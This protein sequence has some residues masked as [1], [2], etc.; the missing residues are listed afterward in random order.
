[1]IKA[2]RNTENLGVCGNV[3]K[4]TKMA[5]GDLV[6]LVAGD[7]LLPAGILAKYTRF[8]EEN[9]LDC[10]EPF[11]IYTNAELLMPDGSR[12][13]KD[14]YNLLEGEDPLELTFLCDMYVWDT[15]LSGGLV[16][17]TP[18]LREDIGFQADWLQ[19]VQRILACKRYSRM[20]E[21]GYIYRVG[22]G[23]TVR[24]KVERQAKSFLAV[25]DIF[26]TEYRQCFTS[27]VSRF[28]NFMESYSS[29]Q[30]SQSAAKYWR[31]VI[32]RF[33]LRGL[34]KQNRHKYNYRVFI[35]ESLKVVI[36]KMLKR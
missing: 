16:K 23:V 3:N 5:T 21:T 33:K 26:K 6:N 9:N 25:I 4:V 35:P 8:I 30:I 32:D 31:Y 20:N 18:L 11:V 1:M 7:D 24:E 34:S 15:G 28:L 19:H 2:Y 13:F 36:R 22:G 12:V 29:Y 14:N 27:R 17:A 10:N